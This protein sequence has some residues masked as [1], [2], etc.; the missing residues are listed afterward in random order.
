MTTNKEIE[1]W[2]EILAGDEVLTTAILDR[3]QH[4]SHVPD[5]KG[6]SHRLRDFERLV[7]QRT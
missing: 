4:N 7:T 5:S 2:P 6:R 1:D 3:L